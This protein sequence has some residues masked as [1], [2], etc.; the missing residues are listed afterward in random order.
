MVLVGGIFCLLGCLILIWNYP[1]LKHEKYMSYMDG[2]ISV[3]D[4]QTAEI[5]KKIEILKQKPN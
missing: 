3:Y 4:E 1:D 2:R 5:N